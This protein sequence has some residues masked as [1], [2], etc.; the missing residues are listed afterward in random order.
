V[1]CSCYISLR[2][3]AAVGTHGDARIHGTSRGCSFVVKHNRRQELGPS[4]ALAGHRESFVP[5]SRKR[6][7]NGVELT[8]PWRLLHFVPVTRLRKSIARPLNLLH[9]TSCVVTEARSKR[10]RLPISQLAALTALGSF[11]SPSPQKKA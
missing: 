7:E 11:N 1:L 2:C 5:A 8:E 3:L 10:R 6:L 4:R 9:F